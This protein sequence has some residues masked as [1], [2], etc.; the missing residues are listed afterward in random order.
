MLFS[1]LNE[2]D[3]DGEIDAIVS[4]YHRLGL[5]ITWC[6]YPWTRP[7]DLSERLL[8]RGATQT[9]I[10]A[11][12]CDTA[13][14][15]EQVD[16]VDVEQVDPESMEAYEAYIKILSTCNGF[17]ADEEAFRRRHY[18][19]LSS[20]PKPSMQLFI[21]RYKGA[22]AGCCATVIKE[23]SGHLMGACVLPAFQ[24]HG[25]FQSFNATSLRALRSLGITIASGHGNEKSAP[26]VK[27]FGFKS[28]Y[29]YG[30]YQLDPPSA[31]GER[32]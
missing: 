4:E 3:P 25:V 28:I 17:S 26:W 22:V 8:A 23:D 7:R 19:Q 18:R 21:G 31:A 15:L 32:H 6:V 13:L 11:F 2:R 12:L 16:N 20:G 29:S 10:H 1:N 27:R 24:A 30:M 14:P 5:P 9:L